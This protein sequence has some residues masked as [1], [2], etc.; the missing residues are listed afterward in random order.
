LRKTEA[1]LSKAKKRINELDDIITRTFEHGITEQIKKERF[2]FLIN[3]YDIEQA[4]LK[5]KATELEAIISEA[6]SQTSNTEKFLE[7][8]REVTIPTELT[9]ELC[10]KLIECI[11]VG[12]TEFVGAGHHNKRQAIRIRYNYIGDME[13]IINETSYRART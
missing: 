5:I 9:R 7:L 3:R 8:I 2:E 4:E 1:E 10:Y 13:T 12:K 6:E 11:F